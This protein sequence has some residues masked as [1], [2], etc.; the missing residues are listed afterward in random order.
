M[1]AVPEKSHPSILLKEGEE[2]SGG[3]FL[4]P[5]IGRYEQVC[6][7]EQVPEDVGDQK[8]M[9]ATLHLSEPDL[10]VPLFQI[11][12]EEVTGNQEERRNGNAAK[13][14]GEERPEGIG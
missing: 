10:L 6:D 11:L 5:E 9:E 4:R 14:L 1:V 7:A 2:G 13:T 8:R 12:E 3:L